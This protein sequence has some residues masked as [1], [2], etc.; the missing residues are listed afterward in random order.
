[1]TPIGRFNFAMNAIFAGLMMYVIPFQDRFQI[2]L[3]A[4]YCF[5]QIIIGRYRD[6]VLLFWDDMKLCILSHGWYL[7]FGYLILSGYHPQELVLLGQHA[8]V[9][10]IFTVL[11]ARY[12]RIFLRSLFKQNVMVLGIGPSAA[13]LR[14]VVA[15]NR[16]SLMDIRCFIDCND[17]GFF[18]NVHQPVRMVSDNVYP[19]SQIDA[20]LR[21]EHIDTL[22]VGITEIDSRDMRRLM[23]RCQSRVENIYYLPRME[24]LITFDSRI[25]DFD[26]LVM[27][28]NSDGGPRPLDLF[29]KRIVDIAAGLAGCL[30]LLP[31]TAFVFIRNRCCGDTGPLFFAQ[32]RIGRDG[33]TFRC[34]KFRTMVPDAEKILN[35]LLASDPQ[36]REEYR[37]NKKLQDDPRITEAG[38]FLRTKSLDEFPQFINVLKGDMSLVGPRPY[39]PREK[40]DMGEYYD[41]II[42]MKPGVT[43]MWQT[44]G[45][46]DV[47]FEERLDLDNYYQHNWN[48]WLDM[49]LLIKTLQV[50]RHGRGAV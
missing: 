41:P 19:F 8:L 38:Q 39:L 27:I 35:D 32:E 16:F 15:T 2:R 34:Y 1:M 31:L 49:T 24:N 33:R 17:S 7:V 28:S 18:K 23:R 37:V 12:S 36:I 47:S 40:E 30:V 21:R 42:Q 44:H 25:K 14:D 26:G 11:C 46:S 9:C 43:G 20:L 10:F 3:L 13:K 4:A 6:N 45:R 22:I 48:I 50:L 5:M 29:C